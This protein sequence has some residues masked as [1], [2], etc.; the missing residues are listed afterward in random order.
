[1]KVKARGKSGRDAL[2]PPGGLRGRS[3]TRND[4]AR[5]LDRKTKVLDQKFERRAE[6]IAHCRAPAGTDA[7]LLRSLVLPRNQGGRRTAGHRPHA[8]G[9]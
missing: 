3:R 2:A 5:N 1:M 8:V 4:G 7:G 6:V 9:L